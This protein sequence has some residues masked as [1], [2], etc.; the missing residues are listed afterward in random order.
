MRAR[1]ASWIGHFLAFIGL[2]VAFSAAATTRVT[3]VRL[4]SGPEGTRLVLDL[5]GPVKHEVFAI[6]NPDRI[7]VDLENAELA[8]PGDLPD[9]QGPVKAVRAGPQPNHGLRLVLDLSSPQRVTKTF[10]V[11]PDGTSGNR[12]VVELPAAKSAAPAGAQAQAAVAA[13]TPVR[14]PEASKAVK[15]LAVADANGRDLV[16]AVDAGHGGQ[17]PGAIGRGG[18]R[19]KDVTLAIARRLAAEINGQEGMRAVLIRDGDYFIT[20]GGRTRKARQ[21]G[22][23]MFVSI[24]ADSVRNRDI[25]GASVY[26]L[27]LRG[28]SDE[29]SRWLAERE[30]A[31]DLMGGVSLDDKDDVLASVLLDVTQKESVSNSVE[32]ADSVLVALRRIGAVHRERVQHAGFVVLKSPDIPSMLVETAFISN[33]LDERRLRDVDQQQRLAEAIR[34]GVRNYFYDKPPPGTKIAAVVAARQG[35]NADAAQQLAER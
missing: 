8:A 13:A 27:S 16:I 6:E 35:G 15:K 10:S 7:V 19:E 4:W 14:Q 30:N 2:T 11:G 34:T 26:V 21:L 32:A 29:A 5:S 24:H 33:S 12:L 17:D 28:A 1:P 22:A 3:D 25:S 31:A 23:D 18:T 9:G 20:L